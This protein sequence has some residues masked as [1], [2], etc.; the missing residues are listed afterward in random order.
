MSPVYQVRVK[1][2]ARV[3]WAQFSSGWVN[4]IFDGPFCLNVGLSNP[5]CSPQQIWPPSVPWT[6]TFKTLTSRDYCGHFDTNLTRS[7]HT[8]WRLEQ[9]EVFHCWKPKTVN[10][11]G[12]FWPIKMWVRIWNF[13]VFQD[14]KGILSYSCSYTK[15]N[16]SVPID[17]FGPIYRENTADLGTRTTRKDYEYDIYM[18]AKLGFPG[19]IPR[20]KKSTGELYSFFT[21]EVAK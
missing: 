13:Q 12:S 16:F 21:F 2:T 14:R 3:D 7:A 11:F 6:R 10:I 8:G 1:K 20:I 5:K 4:G 15:T 17:C 9:L 18:Y 19:H